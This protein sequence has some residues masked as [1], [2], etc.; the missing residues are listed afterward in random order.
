R[1]DAGAPGVVSRRHPFDFLHRHSSGRTTDSTQAATNAAG[2]VLDNAGVLA[3]T[4]HL[5]I[6]RQEGGLQ[7]LVATNGHDIYQAQATLRANIRAS[8]TQ[9]ALVA[10]KDWTDVAFQATQCLDL[11]LGHWITLFDFGDA[12][13]A[14]HWQA[15]RRTPDELLVIRSHSI[16]LGRIDGG[17]CF[18]FGFGNAAGQVFCDR[19]GSSLAFGD[20]G[21]NDAGTK[22]QISSGEDIR[23][24]SGQRDRVGLNRASR[25][26]LEGILRANPGQVGGL[27]DGQDHCVAENCFLAAFDELGTKAAILIKDAAAPDQLNAG[28]FAVAAQHTLRPQAS[29]ELDA[30]LFSLLDLLPGGRNFIEVFKAK[31]VDFGDAFANGFPG[32]V[33]SEPN[34]IRRFRLS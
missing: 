8:A 34:F 21:D 17:A 33:Q 13:P 7:P 14:L 29:M 27:T 12:Y 25:R 22:G 32:Y 15:G 16:T 26:Q 20:S 10:I 19:A 11:G 3:R 31:H 2:F 28:D 23:P 1:R 9:D 4:G 6:A 30:F 24:G 18:E 5:S